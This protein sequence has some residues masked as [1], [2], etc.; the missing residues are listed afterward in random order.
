MSKS[1][2]NAIFM[3]DPPEVVAEKVQSAFTTPT[4]IRKTDPGDPENC[5]VCQLRRVYDP[6]NYMV[7]W[8]EDRAGRRGCVQNKKEL[9]EVLNAVLDPIRR[10]RAELLAD[11]A[12]IERVLKNGAQ[13]ARAVA[14][15]TMTLV[16]QAMKMY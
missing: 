15:E 3:S 10:R 7:S 8:E 1:F 5:V 14:S 13:R 4:K 9:T 6:D 11:P 16:R 12:E 2:G